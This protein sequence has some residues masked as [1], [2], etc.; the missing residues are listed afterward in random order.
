LENY[1][2]KK[3]SQIIKDYFYLPFFLLIIL[4]DKSSNARVPSPPV[5]LYQRCIGGKR[6]PS[7]FPLVPSAPREKFL[8]IKDSV[9]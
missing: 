2:R 9:K 3:I 8:C 7:S 6:G 1:S 5:P 4:W